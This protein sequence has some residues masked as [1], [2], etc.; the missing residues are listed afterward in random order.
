MTSNYWPFFAYLPSVKHLSV[1]IVFP[2]VR[3]FFKKIILCYLIH[4][5]TDTWPFRLDENRGRVVR[6]VIYRRVPRDLRACDHDV[7]YT[8]KMTCM[9]FRVKGARSIEFVIPNV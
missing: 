2:N 4:I 7:C 3:I 5:A 9:R 6:C 8:G 1:K